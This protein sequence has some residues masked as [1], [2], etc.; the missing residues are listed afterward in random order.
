MAEGLMV[1]EKAFRESAGI[2]EPL[3][4][5]AQHRDS[6]DCGVEG[7]EIIHVSSTFRS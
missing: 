5:P 6:V 7:F 4:G 3:A 2:G 1:L